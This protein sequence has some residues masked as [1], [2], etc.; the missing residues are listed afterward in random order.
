MSI[1]IV[2]DGISGLLALAGDM[3]VVC[4]AANGSEAPER[5]KELQPSGGQYSYIH[6][7]TPVLGKVRRSLCWGKE[8][9]DGKTPQNFNC[10]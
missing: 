3:R 5:V 9:N 10:G 7:V 8:G 1:P 2:R 4:E 6:I